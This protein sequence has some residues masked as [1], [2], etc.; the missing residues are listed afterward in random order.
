MT[1]EEILEE[2]CKL[3]KED[4]DKVVAFFLGVRPADD[5]SRVRPEVSQRFKT[6]ASEVIATNHELF[7]KL[8][9]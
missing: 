3:P 4:Q 2:F 9:D 5:G 7:K 6:L 8:T 1:V